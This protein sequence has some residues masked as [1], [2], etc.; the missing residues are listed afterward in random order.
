MFL[1]LS[2]LLISGHVWERSPLLSMQLHN[3]AGEDSR[4]A[5]LTT[6]SCKLIKLSC[7]VYEQKPAKSLLLFTA[8]S[9]TC[10]E[11]SVD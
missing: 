11:T 10:V 9:S 6:K 3:E 1:L 8:R 7:A 2:L 4:P 5:P